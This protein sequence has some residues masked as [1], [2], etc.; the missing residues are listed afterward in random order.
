MASKF[1]PPTEFDFCSPNKWEDWKNRFLRFRLA[2]KLTKESGEEQVSSLIYAMGMEAENILKSFSLSAADSKVFDTVIGKFDDH[3]IPKRNIIHERAK[4]N[5]RKQNNGESAEQF[6]RSLHEISQNCDFG[7]AKNDR[8]RDA[9]VIGVLDK[10]LSEK[11]QLKDDLTLEDATTMTR[12]SELV[13]SQVREQTNGKDVSEVR[14]AAARPR[15]PVPGQKP[16]S[17]PKGGLR[18]TQMRT[19]Q[20]PGKQPGNV[21]VPQCTRC[22][23][24]HGNQKQCPAMGQLCKK[25]SRPNHFAICCQTKQVHEIS[26]NVETLQNQVSNESVNFLESCEIDCDKTENKPWIVN[27]EICKSNIPFKIDSG[28]DTSIISESC[29][30]TLKHRPAL[31]KA[32]SILKSP[33]GNVNCLGYFIADTYKEGQK[34]LFRIYVVAGK[35]QANLLSRGASSALKLVKRIDEIPD[36]VFGRTGRINCEPVKI[37]LKP[38]A[39]PYSVSTARRIPFP[40]LPKVKEELENMVQDGILTEVS[41]PTDW[42]FPMVPV[43]KPNGNVRICVDYKKLNES[44]KRELYMLPN[45]D[46]IAP[47]LAGMTV[48]SKLDAAQGFFQLPLSS[49]SSELT[50]FITPFGRYKYQ[51]VPM[52]TSL[53]PE[54]FQKKITE[55]L[56]GLENVDAIMDDIIVYGR[57][58][59]DHDAKLNNVLHRVNEAGLKLN[60]DKCLFRQSQLEYFGHKINASGISPIRRK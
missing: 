7:T 52:G 34:F 60:K 48:F 58:M 4:F 9:I 57:N 27:L 17:P 59:A 13:K 51:R 36:T 44:I 10:E 1:A 15:Q 5:Q 32:L 21:N 23:R 26:Q 14:G 53:G 31:K 6:I 56:Q 33:G 45:L 55:L 54:I 22:N 8:I 40:L 12:Q 49:E 29:Y 28:A 30:K 19:T 37:E 11:L 47:K 24:R 18:T 25:C 41:H 39:Q 3:F 2:S 50:T 43:L 38:D 35:D 16:R 20:K 42:C 46:D